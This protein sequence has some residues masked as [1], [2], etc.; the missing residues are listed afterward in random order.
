[1]KIIKPFLGFPGGPVVKTVLPL[2]GAQ[3]SSLVGKLGS[4]MSGNVDKKEKKSPPK[5]DLS[6]F[7][8]RNNEDKR[9]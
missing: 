9:H 1:M 2:Q 8:V 3:V 6:K 5:P 4:C 7:I